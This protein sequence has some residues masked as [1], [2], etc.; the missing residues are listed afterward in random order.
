M[1]RAAALPGAETVLPWLCVAARRSVHGTILHTLGRVGLRTSAD[2][3]EIWH[4]FGAFEDP[5]ARHAFLHTVRSI[6]DVGGQRVSATDKLYLA[7]ELPT[8]IVWGARDPLIPVR[9]A[10]EAHERIPG[11][12]LEVF[13]RR[14]TFPTATSRSASSRLSSTSSRRRHPCP[15]DP[16]RLRRRL[17]AGPPPE[18]PSLRR[19]RPSGRPRATE[20]RQTR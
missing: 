2:L 17:R 12:R 3:E 4:S 19:R 7:G 10:H 20:K 11:S 18:P 1:L 8:L 14:V 9:H 5:E 13:P 6:I 16:K 15:P